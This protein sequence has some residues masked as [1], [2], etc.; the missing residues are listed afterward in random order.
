[1]KRSLASQVR[2]ILQHRCALRQPFAAFQDE[3]G[4]CALGRHDKEL[5]VVVEH[6]LASD[7]DR[8]I[9]RL[10]GERVAVARDDGEPI[11]KLG[12]RD[13]MDDRGRN[14]STA[15]VWKIA[16]GAAFRIYGDA[17]AEIE[18]GARG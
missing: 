2:D 1:M 15:A 9:P 18:R 11:G 17:E 14:R 3:H 4:D 5:A 13:V 6:L 8:A 7:I 12:E 10:L 16:R